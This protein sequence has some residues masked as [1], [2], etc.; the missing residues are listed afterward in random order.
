MIDADRH[1]WYHAHMR[2]TE[3]L[4]AVLLF[5]LATDKD[6]FAGDIPKPY[7]GEYGLVKSFTRGLNPM[8]AIREVGITGQEGGM[9]KL[10]TALLQFLGADVGMGL[11]AGVGH[12]AGKP[13]LGL[14]LAILGMGA[15]Q[16]TGGALAKSMH[17]EDSTMQ[18]GN[19]LRGSLSAKDKEV[20]PQHF[21]DLLSREGMDRNRSLK[22]LDMMPKY[23]PDVASRPYVKGLL[24][25]QQAHYG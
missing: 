9:G 12:A 8:N 11:G 5:K 19:A 15:G 24:E 25:S 4:D 16:A 10:R 18:F 17:N 14:L 21:L 23:A 1:M 7:L 20:L 3:C 6:T 22:I 13:G 2:P